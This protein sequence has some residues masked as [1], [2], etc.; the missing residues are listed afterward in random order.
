MLQLKLNTIKKINEDGGKIILVDSTGNVGDTSYVEDVNN[1]GSYV[2]VTN[3]TG[4]G[5]PNA[6]RETM[7]FFI[8]GTLDTTTGNLPATFDVASH[9]ASTFY[10]VNSV[11]SVYSFYLIAVPIVTDAFTL[12]PGKSGFVVLDNKIYTMGN[13]GVFESTPLS[14]ID[15]EYSSPRTRQLILTKN[16]TLFTELVSK[17][18]DLSVEHCNERDITAC[19][20]AIDDI[21]TGIYAATYEFEKGNFIACAR[22]IELM[23]SKDYSHILNL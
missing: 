10:A 23:N 3:S 17:R 15:S 4:Y 22:I 11:D 19:S 21:E 9:T 16:G 5:T 14:L 13:A 7:A 2:L 18:V 8:T 12:A 6:D 1:E 20:K